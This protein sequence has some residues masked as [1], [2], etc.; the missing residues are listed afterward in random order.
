MEISTHGKTIFLLIWNQGLNLPSASCMQD[1]VP[2]SAWPLADTVLASRSNRGFVLNFSCLWFW[3]G[4]YSA[5]GWLNINMSSYQY[6]NCHCCNK[7]ILWLYYLHN[8]IPCT[9]KMTSLNLGIEDKSP[10]CKDL[11][12]YQSSL[13][14]GIMSLKNFT[15]K[16]GFRLCLSNYTEN[17][18]DGLMQDCSNSIA[19]AMELLQSC[20]RPSMWCHYQSML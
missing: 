11:V 18:I 15:K 2:H 4:V 17:Y 10:N 14:T 9:G 20:T 16:I 7:M 8:W 13:R 1:P 5:G 19:N 6:R 12:R 3:M